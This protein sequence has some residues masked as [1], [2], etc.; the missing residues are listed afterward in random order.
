MSKDDRTTTSEKKIA[1][2]MSVFFTEIGHEL[3]SY[4]KPQHDDDI[5]KLWTLL[6]N[7]KTLFL[8][9]V[10]EGEVLDVIKSLDV[11]K[12]VGGTMRLVFLC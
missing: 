10:S 1:N 8:T 5:N 6:R 11:K 12:S 7:G 3:N 4:L 2:D 9:P